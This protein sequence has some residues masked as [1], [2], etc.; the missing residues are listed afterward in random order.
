[1]YMH[2]QE[3]GKRSFLQKHH[4]PLQR[5]VFD[6]HLPSDFDTQWLQWTVSLGRWR[7]W[8]SGSSGELEAR[9]CQEHKSRETLADT[10]A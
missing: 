7:S 2:T 5:G 8:S 1:M 3:F 6:F 4:G 9:L 10:C